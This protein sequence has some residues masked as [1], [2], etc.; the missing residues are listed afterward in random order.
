MR[1]SIWLKFGKCIGGLKNTSI[2]YGVNL[3][4]IKEVKSDFMHKSK[5][6]FC[7]AYSVNRFEEHLKISI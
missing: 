6:N 1:A 7:Q 3:I 4:N 2:K 5:L